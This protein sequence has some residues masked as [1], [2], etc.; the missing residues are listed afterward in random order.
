MKPFDIKLNEISEQYISAEFQEDIFH[1]YSS[2]TLEKVEQ[3]LTKKTSRRKVMN[4]KSISKRLV[5]VIL[6]TLLLLSSAAAYAAAPEIREYFTKLFSAANTADSVWYD[7]IHT[8]CEYFDSTEEEVSPE[9]HGILERA[10]QY[11][12]AAET[13]KEP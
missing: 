13:E 5:A 1:T 3:I 7:S 9:I 6:C 12:E 10:V 8:V 2:E 11:F 4:P